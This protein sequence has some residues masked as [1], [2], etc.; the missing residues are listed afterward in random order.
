MWR[1]LLE[2][3]PWIGA[4]VLFLPLLTG[5]LA[6]LPIFFSPDP[7]DISRDPERA[8]VEAS[9]AR[10]PAPSSP[11]FILPS[12]EPPDSRGEQ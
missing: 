8:D 3:L 6:K 7:D 9:L 12:D 2:R 1:L 11:D 10:I 4:I 5:L